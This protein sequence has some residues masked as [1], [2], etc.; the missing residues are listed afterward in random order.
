[1]F[2]PQLEVANH[3][4]ATVLSFAPRS[5]KNIRLTLGDR[6]DVT[7]WLEQASRYGYDRLVIHECGDLDPPEV[8]NFL[9][10]Y[11]RGQA[12]ASWGIARTGPT[13][14]AWCCANGADVGRFASI[15]DALTALLSRGGKMVPSGTGAQVI[16][17]FG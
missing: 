14:L 13:V 1:V 12:W 9:S 10:V 8:D 16:R 6:M 5:D 3:Q 15:G 11:R 17:A 7:T 2:T 4:G